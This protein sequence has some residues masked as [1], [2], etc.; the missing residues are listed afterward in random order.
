MAVHHDRHRRRA[1]CAMFVRA[2][3]GETA[4]FRKNNVKR[5][6]RSDRSR[7]SVVEPVGGRARDVRWQ[8]GST[9]PPRALRDARASDPR[10]RR[11]FG[12]TR[13]GPLSEK[14]N[15]KRSSRS[16]GSTYALS[17]LWAAELGDVDGRWPSIRIDIAAARSA[18]C[19]CERPTG[20]DV[21][22]ASLAAARSP[23]KKI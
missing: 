23:K 9:S 22:S 21:S 4:L 13:G 12:E 1:F 10:G 7:A 19:S 18:R 5:S 14:E 16:A 15:M 8:S 6:S 11:Q 2:N 20:G 17:N 3:H